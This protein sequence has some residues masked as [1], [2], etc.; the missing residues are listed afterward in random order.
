M[1]A[2]ITDLRKEFSD[3]ITAAFTELVKAAPQLLKGS[4]NA[5]LAKS[6]EIDSDSE[7]AFAKALAKA[8]R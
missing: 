1:E 4:P 2:A 3:A 7:G 8:I 5:S 6:G